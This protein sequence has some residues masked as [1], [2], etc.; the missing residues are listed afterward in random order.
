MAHY[1]IRPG[2]RVRLGRIDPADTGKQN[3]E[4]AARAKLERDSGR[5][6]KLQD[7][8]Y[9][10]R[11]HAVLIV[12]QGMDTSG[13]DGTVKHV[14]SGVN[15]SGCEVV[16]FKLPT[17]EEAAHDFLWRA[18]RAT[19]RRGHITIFNRSH[20]EDVLVPRVHR[21][22]PRAVVRRRYEQINDF[23]RMLA[24]NGTLVVK[25]FLHISKGEQRRR[26]GER[27]ADPD[28]GWKFSAH[29]LEER[30]LWK[31]YATA[32]E[33]LLSRCS[34]AHAPWYVIPA[35]HKWVARAVVADVITSSLR[36]LDLKYPELSNDQRE[37]LV[38]AKQQLLAD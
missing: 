7:V 8:L 36:S 19:P 22:V 18:H 28:K 38:A 27:L 21:T 35:D 37:R 3:D 34:T 13:K 4:A 26:L 9:A 12:L 32:Y 15:P 5:L 24:D 14:M 2:A 6:A 25:F 31:R 23:E 20:Y 30:A 1:R 17:E 11:R 33:K 29:D 16:S 10:E